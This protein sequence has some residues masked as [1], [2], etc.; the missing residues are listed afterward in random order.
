MVLRVEPPQLHAAGDHLNGGFYA[1]LPKKIFGFRRG[2]DDAVKLVAP[3]FGVVLGNGLGSVVSDAVGDVI[4]IV[5]PG[6][7]VRVDPGT[8]GVPGN[9][10]AQKAH[11]ELTVGMDYIEV[12]VQG[13]ANGA[14]AGEGHIPVLQQDK[15]GRFQVVIVLALEGFPALAF[16]GV[17]VD[18]MA[19]AFQ[20]LGK[21]QAGGGY[22]ID[23]RIKGIRKNSNF[24]RFQ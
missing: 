22:P 1:V 11:D 19:P 24:H 16:G 2:G 15:L 14:Y 21:I 23:L 12:N 8:A 17:D 13:L 18:L 7:V 9:I 20:L 6:G 4:G 5:L 3:P 10:A